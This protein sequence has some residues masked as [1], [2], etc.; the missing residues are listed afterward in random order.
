MILEALK[1]KTKI[2][3]AVLQLKNKKM[4]IWKAGQFKGKRKQKKRGKISTTPE[5]VGRGRDQR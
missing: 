1:S 5:R 3:I 4:K 2:V